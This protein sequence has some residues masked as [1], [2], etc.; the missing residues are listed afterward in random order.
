M[1]NEYHNDN[2]VPF[3]FCQT[4]VL[5]NQIWIKGFSLLLSFNVLAWAEWVS[6]KNKTHTPAGLCKKGL[7]CIVLGDGG[8][9][10]H[11]SQEGNYS[12]RAVDASFQTW[13]T[14]KATTL[15]YT[16]TRTSSRVM[17]TQTTSIVCLT[18]VCST[19]VVPCVSSCSSRSEFGSTWPGGLWGCWWAMTLS[20]FQRNKDIQRLYW[21]VHTES[22]S[23]RACRPIRLSVWEI[24]S[25]CVCD[26]PY[27]KPSMRLCTDCVLLILVET[28]RLWTS[29]KKGREWTKEN[30]WCFERNGL[31]LTVNAWG[32]FVQSI[33]GEMKAY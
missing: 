33:A 19:V 28:S 14:H 18:V 3:F 24:M 6:S 11:L 10:G 25:V 4:S 12:H 20:K 2:R 29:D 1:T 31:R 13:T 15:L 9:A 16:W 22:S 7:Q 21:A 8:W 30:T 17:I 27:C 26:R 5:G 23:S 32:E